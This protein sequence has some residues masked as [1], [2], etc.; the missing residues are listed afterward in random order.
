VFDSCMIFP[1]EV[2]TPKMQESALSKV[3]ASIFT[4][5]SF[6]ATKPAQDQLLQ[7]PREALGNS[8]EA[9]DK[10]T[11]PLLLLFELPLD[12]TELGQREKYMRARGTTNRS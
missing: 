11:I 7:K 1:T 6:P 8:N 12:K 5:E 10:L 2:N 9:I 3:T 4:S